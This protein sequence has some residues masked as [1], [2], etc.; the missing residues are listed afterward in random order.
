MVHGKFHRFFIQF[1]NIPD[2][3]HFK[4][5]VRRREISPNRHYRNLCFLSG[6]YPHFT[7][8][9]QDSYPV[10]SLIMLLNFSDIMR[11]IQPAV[12]PLSSKSSGWMKKASLSNRIVLWFPE[13]PAAF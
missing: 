2:F 1:L 9:Y 8:M 4:G 13:P 5:T 7:G 12:S 10:S 6:R 3:R 11:D